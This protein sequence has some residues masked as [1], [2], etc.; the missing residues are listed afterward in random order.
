MFL[1]AISP[2]LCVGVCVCRCLLRLPSADVIRSNDWVTYK[3][4]ELYFSS[5]IW[6]LEVQNWNLMLGKALC[7]PIL[8]GEGGR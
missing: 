4:T 2:S 5:W 3:G 8:Y 7:C 6:S 1:L